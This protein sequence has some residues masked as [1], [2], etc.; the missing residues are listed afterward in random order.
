MG[1]TNLVKRVREER[2]PSHIKR[3]RPKKS[4]DDVMKEDMKKFCFV[5]Q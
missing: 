4:W 5:H 1:E 3:E 2:V